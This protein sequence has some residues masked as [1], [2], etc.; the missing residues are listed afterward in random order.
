VEIQ[1]LTTCRSGAAAERLAPWAE[2]CPPVL[3]DDS[4]DGTAANRAEFTTSVGNLET[5]MGCAQFALGADIR[6]NAGAFIA[7]GC[8]KNSTDATV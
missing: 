6:V 5:E 3:H 2:V 7:D 4:F 8:L 1:L